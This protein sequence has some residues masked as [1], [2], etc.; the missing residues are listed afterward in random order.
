MTRTEPIVIPPAVVDALRNVMRQLVGDR[1]RLL[2]SDA[3]PQ[4]NGAINPILLS[5][6]QAGEVLG[7][8]ETTVRQLWR[9]GDLKCVH[10]GRGRK[11]S[12][13][14]I[15]RYINDHEHFSPVP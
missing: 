15:Q 14:E 6:V 10:I 5:A 12:T 13:T 2:D 7:I 8:N 4:V 9:D 11:V 3:R 1:D